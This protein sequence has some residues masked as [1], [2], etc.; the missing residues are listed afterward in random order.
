M[1]KLSPPSIGVKIPAFYQNGETIPLKIPF[2]LNKAV[3]I[4]EV[5]NIHIIIKTTSTGSV[6]FEGQASNIYYDYDS[7]NYVA[8][9]KLEDSS[10][11]PEPAQR[12]KIQIACVDL[13]DTIG[14]YSSVGI[15]KYTTEPRVEILNR[16]DTLN[17]S[18]EYT[19]FYSQQGKDA[20]EKVYSY[21]F[22]LYDGANNLIETSGE[23]LHNSATDTEFYQSTDVWTIKKSLELNKSYSIE[24]VVNTINGLSISSGRYE[25]IE[26]ALEEPN[27]HADLSAINKFEDGF[28]EIKLVGHKDNFKINGYFTLLRSASIDGFDSWIEITKFQL[29]RWDS[30]EVKFLCNDFTV[31]QGINYKYAIQAYNSAGTRSNRLENIE[32]AVYCDFEDAFL[33]DGKKQLKIRFNPK[34]TNFKSTLLESKTN[35]IGSKY[36]FIFRNGNVNYKEF[37]ISGLLSLLSDE[38]NLFLTNL[39]DVKNQKFVDTHH[40]TG[41]NYRKEREFKLSVLEWLNDGKPK[42]FRS[43]AEGNFIVRLMNTSLTPNDTLGRMLHTF[44]TSASEIMDCSYENMRALS[45]T[46]PSYTETRTLQFKELSGKDLPANKFIPLSFGAYYLSISNA[47]GISIVVKYQDGTEI[48]RS[49][50]LGPDG[51][52][53]DTDILEKNPIIAI[54][55]GDWDNAIVQYGYYD[56]SL[57]TFSYIEKVSTKDKIVQI[58]GRNGVNFI[59]DKNYGLEDI[60]LKTGVFH[61]IK[62]SLRPTKTIYWRNGREYWAY[63]DEVP[64]DKSGLD[65]NYL[66]LVE[67]SNRTIIHYYDGRYGWEPVTNMSKL[68][69]DF[70]I[71]GSETI[72]VSLSNDPS[73]GAT[74]N[75]ITGITSLKE[76]YAGDGIQL[77]IVYQENEL[78]YAVEIEGNPNSNE[79]LKYKNLWLNDKNAYEAMLGNQ[80]ISKDKLALAEA[81]MNNS[82]KNYVYVLEQSLNKLKEENNVEFAI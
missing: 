80:G 75:A 28:V 51:M 38:N 69:Y 55:S 59:I 36:P 63:G 64:V 30:N 74:Y 58:I 45:F 35:T 50:G 82:Y 29:Y 4:D 65:T 71:E 40:L 78:L 43:A 10:F 16:E 9:V 23:Q 27:V 56:T 47:R 21:I 18:Y 60:R 19:G 15:V 48:S 31:Q 77:D 26:V 44:N 67:D 68:K 20:S 57:D 6:K 72:D 24:Y 37:Q 17:N 41:D 42:L 46:V 70:R 14:Y 13:E 34:I 66:Y 79:V 1:A 73:T 61:Y 52:I 54:K 62:V 32:G 39:I 25:I 53:F 7:K 76:L 12:Y 3:H 2:I 81:R 22:N 33:Y 8:V 11:S 49:L 5:K